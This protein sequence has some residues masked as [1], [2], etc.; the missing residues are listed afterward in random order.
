[1]S[2][3]DENSKFLAE[4]VELLNKTLSAVN[5][6]AAGASNIHA[7]AIQIH[8]ASTRRILVL[9]QLAA[10][11]RTSRAIVHTAFDFSNLEI[12]MS[13]N[14][15]SRFVSERITTGGAFSTSATDTVFDQSGKDEIN[16]SVAA[17][18]LLAGNSIPLRLDFGVLITSG[19]PGSIG[20]P[21]YVC[22]QRPNP[23]HSSTRFICVRI[24]GGADTVSSSERNA[25]FCCVIGAG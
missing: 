12:S 19:F 4:F 16:V 21:S 10:A 7:A 6:V 8:A 3:R 18:A 2:W 5:T 25:C 17:E 15:I 11:V 20:Q 22:A 1:M 9:T 13:P 24:T 14:F 23:R